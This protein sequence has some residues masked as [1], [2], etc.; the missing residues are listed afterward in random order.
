MKLRFFGLFNILLLTLSLT[1]FG[2]SQPRVLVFKKSS[3]Y[4]HGSIPVA[5]LAIIKL[6]QDNGFAVDTKSGS[7]PRRQECCRRRA[8]TLRIFPAQ[9][10]P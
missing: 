4:H 3:G 6:G 9:T 2:Q 7:L 10:P 1:A 5:A 8:R